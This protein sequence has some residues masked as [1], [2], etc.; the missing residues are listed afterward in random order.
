MPMQ[1]QAQ[2][3]RAVGPLVEVWGKIV[4]SGNYTTAVGGDTT[5]FTKMTQDPSFSGPAVAIDSSQPPIQFDAWS[6]A[7]LITY[8][9][10]ANIGSGQNNCQV[11]VGANATFGTELGTGAYPAAVTGDTI[12]FYAAFKKLQ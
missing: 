6:E 1:L 10:A 2:V 8:Q 9:Y 4:A 5:D 11:K 3:I 7:G 12:A